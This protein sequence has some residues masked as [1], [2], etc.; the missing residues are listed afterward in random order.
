MMTSRGNRN[1]ANDLETTGADTRRP[2]TAL[3][4]PTRADRPAQRPVPEPPLALTLE[5]LFDSR[6]TQAEHGADEALGHLV[7]ASSRHLPRA[8]SNAPTCKTLTACPVLFMCTMPAQA[9]FWKPTLDCN[10]FE[11]TRAFRGMVARRRRDRRP[12]HDQSRGPAP[13]QPTRCLQRVDEVRSGKNTMHLDLLTDDLDG[14][15]EE[16]LK[17]GGTPVADHE[18]PSAK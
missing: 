1:P 18:L 2:F 4:S 17:R 9:R 16:V 3:R 7:G 8:G 10:D 5:R 11:V 13:G 14:T 6:L 12:R 15:V